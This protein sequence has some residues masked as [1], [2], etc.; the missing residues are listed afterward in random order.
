MSTS[1]LDH[2]SVH[3]FGGPGHVAHDHGRQVITFVL[4]KVPHVADGL[5]GN[6][7]YAGYVMVATLLCAAFIAFFVRFRRS[8]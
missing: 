1:A 2:A 4:H 7:H 6:G 3:H 8:N 5:F